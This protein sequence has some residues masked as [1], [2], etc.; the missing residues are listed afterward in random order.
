M[1]ANSIDELADK[2]DD[3]NRDALIETIKEFNASITHDVP[4][5]PN[6]KDGRCTQGL[7]IESELGG[8]ARKPPF[9]A[10]P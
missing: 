4:F 6:V 2:L 8:R 3:V 7:A 9:E 1:K 10:T 5:S